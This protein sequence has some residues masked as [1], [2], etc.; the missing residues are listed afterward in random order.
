MINDIND[1]KNQ[2]TDILY[3][4]SWSHNSKSNL[5]IKLEKFA[6]GKIVH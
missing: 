2:N 1:K 6:W 4:S 3:N 5:S